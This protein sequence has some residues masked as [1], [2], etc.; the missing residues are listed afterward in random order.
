L[1]LE[2]DGKNQE[3][4]SINAELREIE[5]KLA[6]MDKRI[7]RAQAAHIR[8]QDESQQALQDYD[9]AIKS[10]DAAKADQVRMEQERDRF[11]YSV[12]E[13]ISQASRVCDRVP[14]ADGDNPTNLEKKVQKLNQDLARYGAE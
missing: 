3:A 2:K 10:I 8:A 13:M 7:K 14:L 4:S 1:V 9:T 6:H 11:L 5:E 12:A